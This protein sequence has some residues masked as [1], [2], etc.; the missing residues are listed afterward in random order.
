MNTRFLC[1]F[2]SRAG[3]CSFFMP[4]VRSKHS[5]LKVD[6]HVRAGL[7]SKHLR[8][9]QRVAGRSAIYHFLRADPVGVALCVCPRRGIPARAQ[10]H[11]Y[12]TEA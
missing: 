8:A 5:L 12:V 6:R 9:A 7:L 1:F 10:R 2:L 3:T 4:I 11:F